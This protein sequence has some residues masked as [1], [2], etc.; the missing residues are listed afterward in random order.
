[1]LYPFQPFY[2]F[3]GLNP[4]R[5]YES[6]KKICTECSLAAPKRI[7]SVSMRKYTATLT[8]M[9]NLDGNL[10]EWVCP[11]LGH[12]A[13]VHKTHYRQMSGFIE[14]VHVSKLMLIKVMNLTK[15][16]AGKKLEDIEITG[17]YLL[18]LVFTKG[19]ELKGATI[20]FLGQLA[21]IGLKYSGPKNPLNQII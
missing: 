8:Q 20:R 10:L 17:S 16:Y 14:R 7:T 9:L 21:D 6:L 15:K 12:S 5:S 13:N 1:M 3:A 11:H 2:L 4:A 18:L 19:I